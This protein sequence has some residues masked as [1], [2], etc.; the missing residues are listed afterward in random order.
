[1]PKRTNK[2][3]YKVIRVSPKD[4]LTSVTDICRLTYKVGQWTRP[5]IKGSKIFA[6]S[7]F[8]NAL[9]FSSMVSEE[10]V[11]IFACECKNSVRGPSTYIAFSDLDDEGR[12]AKL[13]ALRKFWKEGLKKPC[14]CDG[15]FIRA[16]RGTILV[17]SI[18]LVK[19]VYV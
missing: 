9:T 1:M 18:K 12:K 15:L 7:S 3:V 11:A 16:P 8:Q 19:K 5:R 14:T 6:F 13:G 2:K 4:K 17:D 10:K